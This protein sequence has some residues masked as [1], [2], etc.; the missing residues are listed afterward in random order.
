VKTWQLVWHGGLTWWQGLLLAVPLAALVI[1]LYRRELDP[2][3]VLQRRVLPILRA[4]ALV[5]LVLMLTGP[6]LHFSQTFGQRARVLVFVDASESMGLCDAQMEN[7]RKLQVL[8]RMGMLPPDTLDG[9]L[10]AAA[11]ALGG[12]H[13]QIASALAA[14]SSDVDFPRLAHDVTGQVDTALTDLK[15]VQADKL[16]AGVPV[17]GAA[18]GP[19][20]LSALVD[21]FRTEL[22]AGGTAG[23]ADLAAVPA[24]ASELR[25]RLT[26]LSQGALRWQRE[27]DGDLDAYAGRLLADASSP[28]SKA[29]AQFDQMPRMRR[30]EALLLEGANPM[31]SQLSEHAQVEVW[32]MLNS[33]AQQVWSNQPGTKLPTKLDVKPV[34][35]STDLADPIRAQLAKGER[36]DQEQLGII[37]SDGQNNAPTFPKQMATELRGRVPLFTVT[38]GSS[39]LPKDLA[40]FK[41]EGPDSVFHKD[42]LKGQVTLKDDMPAGTPFMV[43]IN[44]GEHTIWSKELTTDRSHMRTVDYDFPVEDLANEYIAQHPNELGARSVIMTFRV[45]LAGLE[46]Q[47]LKGRQTA[48]LVVPVVRRKRQ[49]LLLDGRPRWEFRYLRNAFERD[50]QWDTNSLVSGVGVPNQTWPRGERTGTFPKDKDTLFNYDAIVFGD[51][52]RA[53]FSAA[54]LDAIKEFVATRGGGIIFVDGPR[55]R[56]RQYAGTPLEDLIPVEWNVPGAAADVGG[57]EHLNRA[58]PAGH[59]EGWAQSGAAMGRPA[60]L[61]LTETGLDF[62]PLA[63]LSD[64]QKNASLWESFQ[65]PHWVAVTR[66][67]PGSEVLMEAVYGGGNLPV[68]V[69]RRVGDGHVLYLADDE[70]WRL[71]Y[72]VADQYHP[73]YW[74]QLADWIAQPPSAGRDRYVT[75]EALGALFNSRDKVPLRVRIK[76]S[77]GRPWTDAAAEVVLTRDGAPG[78]VVPLEHQPENPGLYLGTCPPLPAGRYEVAVRI[79]GLTDEQMKA[80][81]QFTVQA[82]QTGELAVLN[83]DDAMMQALAANSGGQAFAEDEAGDLVAH[84]PATDHQ[85]VKEND[86]PL[87]NSWY[88]FGAVL[89]VLAL[90]WLIRKRSGLM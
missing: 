88:W 58:L 25:R 27:L 5:L 86:L 63:L 45:A 6:A 54:E 64:T 32:A 85:I 12:V 75:I 68:M 66:P 80:R 53:M 55:G 51:V 17:G 89:A 4:L 18:G 21:R 82:V 2:R 26:D 60:H 42:R 10:V 36:E 46:N 39:F 43:N 84:L 7:G 23:L 56:L 8:D 3:L 40:I 11:R 14:P 34:G 78:P 90:E 48:D 73:K 15:S 72:L 19:P 30:V 87:W 24:R 67:L 13:R 47:H 33:Q 37:L 70:S 59:A 9:K 29:A 77:L 79:Q 83:A 61:R 71:R 57:V 16:A 50:D 35:G 81:A 41:V 44:F 22:V 52:S 65:T 49:I 38:M 76:N 28:A 20:P 69:T 1:W 74:K 62:G 31:L